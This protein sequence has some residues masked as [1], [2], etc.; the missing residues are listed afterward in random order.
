MT[1]IA[2]DLET[3]GFEAQTDQIIEIA[4]IKF[5]G[6]KIIDR[7]SSLVN[8]EIPIPAMITHITGIKGEDLVDAPRL[9]EIQAKL[10]QFLGNFPIIG[11]N[12]SFDITFL[13]HKGLPIT[14]PLYDTLQLASILLPGLPSY[15]LDTLTR[16]FKIPH[17]EK[18]R[19]D[20][21]TQAC[22]QLF[23]L[24]QQKISEI[25]E[26]MFSEFS[27]IFAKSSW[28][29][30]ELFE[31]SKSQNPNLKAK[32]KSKKQQ[33][34]AATDSSKIPDFPSF[35]SEFYAAKGPLSKIIQ[36]YETRTTQPLLTEKI[37]ECFEKSRH[38]LAEAGTGTGKTIA[39]LLAAVMWA[40]AHRQK[41]IIS[42]YTNNLQNQ[43]LGNDIPLLRQALNKSDIH[44]ET[45]VLKGRRNYLS[46]SRLERFKNKNSFADHEVVLLLKLLLWLEKTET[47]DLDELNLQGKEFQLLDEICCAEYV[48]NHNVD[49]E[50]DSTKTCYLLKARQKAKS[51]DLVIV[52]HA[53]MLQN[54]LSNGELLPEYDF[55]IIDEAHQLEKVATDS[56]T[57]TLALNPCQRPFQK[58]AKLLENMEKS[59][60]AENLSQ[61]LFEGK[62]K[63]EHLL[64]RIE[65][66]FG[67][68]GIFLEKNTH[69]ASF[70]AQVLLKPADYQHHEWQKIK[71]SGQA[72]AQ[73]GFEMLEEIKN[74]SDSLGT[75]KNRSELEN[76]LFE[77]RKRL[78]D[79]KFILAL[80]A[81]T[82]DQITWIFKGN[83][84]SISIKNAPLSVGKELQ[85]MFFSS[86]QSLILTSAT[87]T[88]EG[89]FDHIRDQLSL[90]EN[91][92]ELALPSHFH[93][94]DQ[95]KILIPQDL[96]E[97]A[98][99]G[100]F[101]NC[102]SLIAEII[103]KNQ[104]RTMALFT[105]KK[106]LAATF[107]QI[108]P[109]LKIE[110]FTVLAQQ[111]TGGRGKILEHFKDE[112]EKSAIFGLN[113]FWEGV[114][115]KGNDLTCV[116]IQKLPFD[117]PDDPI[118]ASRS[119]KY[120]DS[121]SEYMIPRAILRFKQ[122]FG[123]LIRSSKDTGSI[124]ILDSRV[125]Q[126]SYGQKF[127]SS[128]PSGIQIKYE[129]K[130]RLTGLL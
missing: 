81:N 47:G 73:I 24:L 34:R 56:F 96:P 98:S 14:N 13:Q 60:S 103:K 80:D 67:L 33:N 5:E 101:S 19:A 117:P 53:L 94:P 49:P 93:Y 51:A 111:I 38:L 118:I 119:Q 11:H 102:A 37:L 107:H 71:S 2:L 9:H 122:G 7:F 21:D 77:C 84:E 55:A 59:F 85:A 45:A 116:I 6:G 4:A 87:L 46:P 42:T 39:Y 83:E 18:H 125:M 76:N 41:I 57:L 95:V 52:N 121:F 3:T 90:H 26:P 62:I 27:K 78:E 66:F 126:K 20:S 106:A 50:A 23:L 113:S 86:R 70:Y 104:G 91:V 54:Q 61:N 29:L 88:T 97:P 8:A 16:I 48:C 115:I 10:L 89:T 105:S 130:D 123:R 79:L 31:K 109:Q 124:V 112:P 64:S 36:D 100:F 44:F 58:L 32:P 128:L 17:E 43:I 22:L 92:E 75:N 108:A 30:K 69:P 72:I 12:I 40:K 15:S 127:L 1:Y 74:F 82:G 35:I 68:V 99:E 114:D 120:S 65:I 129:S 63:N 110:G 28:S 25:N